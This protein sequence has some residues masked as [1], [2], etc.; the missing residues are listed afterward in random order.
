[1]LVDLIAALARLRSYCVAANE[2]DYARAERRRMLE[3]AARYYADERGIGPP[4]A[5]TC[6]AFMPVWSSA[7]QR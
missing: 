7:S 1:M 2:V 4:S 6:V 5:P 3:P